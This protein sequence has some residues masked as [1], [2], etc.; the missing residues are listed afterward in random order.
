[1]ILVLPVAKIPVLILAAAVLL[2]RSPE[3]VSQEVEDFTVVVAAE[4]E[5]SEELAVWEVFSERLVWRSALQLWL[6]KTM[7]S[8]KINQLRW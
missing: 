7:V 6:I 3:E 5:V 8:T 1:M 2:R 4:E